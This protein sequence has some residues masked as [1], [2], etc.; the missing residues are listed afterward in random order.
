VGIPQD[1]SQ[2]VQEVLRANFRPEFLNRLDEIVLFNPLRRIQ[3]SK[4]VEIQVTAIAKILL[5]RGIEVTWE[6]SLIDWLAKTGYDPVYGARPLRRAIQRKVQD[7]LAVGILDGT[8]KDGEKLRLSA[9]E[10]QLVVE[11]QNNTSM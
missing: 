2:K 7:V 10:E 5:E 9:C 11:T 4:I 8:I 1:V 6:S 3:I